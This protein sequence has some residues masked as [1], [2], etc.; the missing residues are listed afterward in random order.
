[1]TL[2]TRARVRLRTEQS[3]SLK[4]VSL[5][6][7]CD[8]QQRRSFDDRLGTAARF[9]RCCSRQRFFQSY[10]DGV[11]QPRC[12]TNLDHGVLAVGYDYLNNS[13]LTSRYTGY[14][15]GIVWSDLKHSGTREYIGEPVDFFEP[16][17]FSTADLRHCAMR[18]FA[19]WV[20]KS[21][22]RRSPCL[23]QA[24]ACASCLRCPLPSLLLLPIW[25]SLFSTAGL[26]RRD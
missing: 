1:M 5:F 8:H 7:G 22:W 24:R 26:H 11:T 2:E 20:G 6:Q 9:N 19:A 14:K 21:H 17:A 18:L 3:D 23:T 12:G 13:D 4:E 15:F 10:S 16:T 25:W